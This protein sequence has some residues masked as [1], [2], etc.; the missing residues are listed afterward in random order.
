MM[1]RLSRSSAVAAS[2]STLRNT[3]V[4]AV[5]Q[6]STRSFSASPLAS[7]LNSLSR[8]S[9]SVS[10]ARSA[11]RLGG[12]L[13]SVAALPLL[14]QPFRALTA[15]AATAAAAGETVSVSTD[16]HFDFR[17]AEPRWRRSWRIAQPSPFSSVCATPLTPTFARG[18]D[19]ERAGAAAS[20]GET[21]SDAAAS[22]A[23]RPSFYSLAMFPYP[24]GS[25]HMGHV[26]VY[27]IS[28]ALA[29][30]YALR[31][32]AVLHP[33]GWDAFGLPAENAEIGRAH[34]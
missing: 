12:A 25:L 15:A 22:P 18:A 27:T 23:E 30:F 3:T 28:D 6:L 20:A 7:C 8:S 4:A 1:L 32:F 14:S 26:R 33:M 13:I 5:A 17:R 31:G 34:G 16:T 29:R 9:N 11:R 21:T 10:S 2:R 24:S 19:D